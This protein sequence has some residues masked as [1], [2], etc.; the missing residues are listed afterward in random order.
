MR[1]A[2]ERATRRGMHA[3]WR[4]ARGLTLGVRGLVI[5][6]DRRIFLVQHTY[7]RGWHL[8]GGGVPWRNDWTT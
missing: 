3:Y 8:P 5:G 6:E 7:V 1:D 2:I 4:F